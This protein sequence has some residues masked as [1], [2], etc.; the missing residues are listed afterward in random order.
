MLV[1]GINDCTLCNCNPICVAALFLYVWGIIMK[2]RLACIMAIYDKSSR[3]SSTYPTT[4]RSFG[5]IMNLAS[6]NVERFMLSLIFISHLFW[7]H[8]QSIGILIMG[9]CLRE[10]AFATGFASLIIIFIPLQYYLSQI[11]SFIVQ[12]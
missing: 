3:F 7:S 10:P 6:I 11:F 1:M 5:Q 8:A 9:I 2:F 12:R 4:S